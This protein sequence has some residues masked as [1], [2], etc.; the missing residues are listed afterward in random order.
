MIPAVFP[1]GDENE[2]G[3]G[4]AFISLAFIGLNIAVFLL[5]QGAGGPEGTAFTYGYSAVPLE[6]TTGQDLT[7]PQPIPGF[8]DPVHRKA[9]R[10]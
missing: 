5:L 8:P 1:I 7:T 4:P 6:I 10:Q 2:R 9:T 3:H